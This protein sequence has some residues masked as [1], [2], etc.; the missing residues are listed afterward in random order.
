MAIVIKKDNAIL[1]VQVLCCG[2]YVGCK[3]AA[4]VSSLNWYGEKNL[5][6][7]VTQVLR[8]WFIL[9]YVLNHKDY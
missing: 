8:I 9:K 1:C 6:F 3:N 4:G 5:K 2:P 7:T